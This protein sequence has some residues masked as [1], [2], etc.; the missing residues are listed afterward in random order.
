MPVL[1]LKEEKKDG[2]KG[3][4]R[5][6]K[7]KNNVPLLGNVTSSQSTAGT[8]LAL[9]YGAFVQPGSHRLSPSLFSFYFSFL[10]SLFPSSKSELKTHFP[11]VISVDHAV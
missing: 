6:K 2:K 7:K 3:K 10:L 5:E 11:P 1:R 8:K 9:I 4:K